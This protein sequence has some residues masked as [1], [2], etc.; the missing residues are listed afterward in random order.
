MSDLL[1]AS[2]R[3]ILRAIAGGETNPA[4]LAQL[5]DKRLRASEAEM[6]DALSGQ[7]QPL[8]R[9]VLSLYLTRLDL[10]ESQMAELEKMIA[11][12]MQAHKET[13]A[14]LAELPGLGV[15]SAQQVIAEIGPRAAAFPSAPQ[16]ASW[17]GVCPGRQESAGESSSNRSA[18]GN[19][20]MRRLLDQLA[21][22]AVRKEGTQMQIVFRRLSARMGY[23]KAI[24]AIA[25][26][27]CRLIW[28]VLHDNVRYVEQGLVATPIALKRRRQRLV[29]QLRK[30]GYQVELTPLIPNPT[31]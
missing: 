23:N 21:H 16:L 26:R 5:G 12:A 29:T 10:I 15:D 11:E 8:Q 1:G 18:K 9:Q 30:M 17:V 31:V 13:I 3:R 20:S 22:A 6:I 4:R 19:R 7:P 25:H 2:G 14:R 27:L 24:W 28:K